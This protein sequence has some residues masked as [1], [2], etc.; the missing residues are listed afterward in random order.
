MAVFFP[1][2]LL[3]TPQPSQQI[4]QMPSQVKPQQQTPTTKARFVRA[5]QP[6]VN[7]WR[8]PLANSDKLTK[9]AQTRLRQTQITPTDLP[10]QILKTTHNCSLLKLVDGTYGWAARNTFRQIKTQNPWSKI[11]HAP[12]NQLAPAANKPDFWQIAQVLNKFSATP[13]LWGGTTAQGLDCSAFTQKFFWQVAKILLPRNSRAQ[14]QC[15]EKISQTKICPL[16]LVFF[17]HH[18]TQKSHVGIF[19]GQKI[20]HFCLTRQG[21]TSEPLTQITQRYQFQTAR[22]LLTNPTKPNPLQKILTARQIHLVGLSSTEGAE[23]AQFLLQQKIQFQAH[24]FQPPAKFTRNFRRNNFALPKAKLLTTLQALK[25]IP[26]NFGANYLANIQK[27]DLICVSQNFAAYPENQ[28]LQKIYAKNP[29]RFLTL[30]QLYF[31]LFPGRI[32]AVT[33]TNGKSTTTKLCAAILQQ[34]PKKIWFTGNDRRN[35][36]ILTQATKW[37]KK[38]WLV[39]EVSNRQLNFPLPRAPEIGVLTNLTPNHLDEYH[40]SFAAYCQTKTQ[41]LR[42]QTKKNFAVLN[43]DN[44]V[45]RQL[46]TKIPGQPIFFSTQTKVTTGISVAKNNW[47]VSTTPRDPNQKS[48]PVV[49]KICPLAKIKIPGQHNLSNALAA[50]AATRLAGAS[51][52]A[53]HAA[54]QN[55]TGLPQRLECVLTK[56]QLQ[57]INDSASTTPESTSAALESFPVGSVQLIAGGADKKMSFAK[58]TQIIKKRQVRVIL[59]QSPVQ[60]ILTPKL[61]K[62]GLVSKTVPTLA[63]A[64]KYAQQQ[65]QKGDKILLSPAAAYFCYFAKRLPNGGRDFKQ[66]AFGSK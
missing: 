27:A 46:A 2:A 25:K 52:K 51:L 10:A 18:Q 16:D 60:K 36:Q 62:L 55:F 24:D 41:L 59:L 33:G 19:W 30:T 64:L 65:A 49:Q 35:Q 32:L 44:P 38:D 3:K 54:L 43:Y 66:L 57:F 34:T 58:L 26:F 14:A 5:K 29:E 1:V 21:L 6:I 45:T 39:I 4:N 53:I 9:R 42:Q 50:I 61:K 47:L 22:R 23:I 17:Q 28:P 63:E 56:N 8:H 37:N 13:Y 20:W 7:L 48:Q 11:F 15:G 31:A 12:Q 40:N